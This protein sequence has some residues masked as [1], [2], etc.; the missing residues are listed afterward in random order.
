MIFHSWEHRRRLRLSFYGESAVTEIDEIQSS[1]KQERARVIAIL[2]SVRLNKIRILHLH[3]YQSANTHVCTILD[4]KICFE[5][6]S[7]RNYFRLLQIDSLENYFAKNEINRL[8][9]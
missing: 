3:A 4:L 6:E 7:M 2:D 8:Y 9:L 1:R 5:V